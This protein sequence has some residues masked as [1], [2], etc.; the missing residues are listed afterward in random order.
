[1]Q[2][3]CVFVM[4]P[5]GPRFGPMRAR[6]NKHNG[7]RVACARGECHVTACVREGMQKKIG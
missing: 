4:R 5:K 7:A 6:I 2:D 3:Y 1:M